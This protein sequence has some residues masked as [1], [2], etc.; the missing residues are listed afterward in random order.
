MEI[1]SITLHI[2]LGFSVNYRRIV[3]RLE[4]AV[5]ELK[6][7]VFSKRIVVDFNKVSKEDILSLEEIREEAG[8]DYIATHLNTLENFSLIAEALNKT[9]RT[10]ISTRLENE[11]FREYAKS[12]KIVFKK[13]SWYGC[14]RYGISIGK[15]PVT[16]Y[17]PVTRGGEYGFSLSILY[18]S[19]LIKN[20]LETI[21]EIFY[22]AYS[23]GCE[24]SR[25]TRIPFI[26]VDYSLSPW[27]DDSVA[28]LI[29][30]LNKASFGEPG[31]L[32]T[33][34]KLNKLIE[35]HSIGLKPIGFNEV[36][37]PVAEDNILKDAVRKGRITLHHLLSYISVCV[38]GLDMVPINYRIS[39][40]K[41]A[42]ILQDLSVLAD[43]KKRTVG[44]RIVLVEG[45]GEVDLGF[46]EKTPVLK[47]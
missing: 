27:M 41:I 13:A 16:P 24:I 23:L 42:R 26:G 7:N 25:K 22:K 5:K 43:L 20:E 3:E 10:F 4:D 15:T 33:I 30:V 12:I 39:V 28:R 46:F 21:P 40:E 35:K 37:L 47:I 1:R 44:V 11:M 32:Q 45:E 38:A 18:A 6:I 8:V 31:T 17:F 2:P 19:D 34:Y 9:E 29:E 14:A 36:M